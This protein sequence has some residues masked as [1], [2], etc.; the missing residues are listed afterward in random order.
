ML[1]YLI[2]C[3]IQEAPDEGL[4]Q[5]DQRVPA[6]IMV[7]QLN[8]IIQTIFDLIQVLGQLNARSKSSATHSPLLSNGQGSVSASF[9]HVG[10]ALHN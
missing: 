9:Q 5:S 1:L 7:K 3:L 8:C 6:S 2:F 4:P 10:V